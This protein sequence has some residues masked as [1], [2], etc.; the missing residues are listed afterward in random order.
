MSFIDLVKKRHSVREYQDKPVEKEKILRCL[1]A[2]RLSPS[3][4]NSQPWRYI[5][6][7]EPGLRKKVC[8]A[9]FSG[10]FFMNKFAAKAP[11]IIVVLGEPDFVVNRL[12]KVVQG[13]Q[14]FLLDIG[15]SIE[16]LLLA[17]QEEGLGAC[18]LGWYSERRI[19]ETLKIPRSKK[20]VSVISM[21]YP[22]EEFER[23]KIRKNIEDISSFN[24]YRQ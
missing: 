16:H 9:A 10:I 15:A 19:K 14:Y 11:V 17:A 18:W 22:A 3:A 2:A 7:D 13:V 12:G 21:G 5:I 23:Q 1:E 20:I 8:D 6:V 4:S 24:S